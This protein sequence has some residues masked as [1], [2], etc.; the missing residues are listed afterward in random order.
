MSRL[1]L[2]VDEVG[3]GALA[4]PLTVAAVALYP[5]TDIPGVRDSK[6]LAP[7]YR[8]EL[9][10]RI[11]ELAAGWAI[12]SSAAQQIDTHG[13][14]AC[15]AAACRA[16]VN[17]CLSHLDPEVVI[18]VDGNRRIPGLKAPHQAVVKADSSVLAVSAA[19][20]IAKVWRDRYMYALAAVYP[21]FDFHKNVGYPTR[22]H[23]AQLK[24]HGPCPE[25]RRSYAPV[26]EVCGADRRVR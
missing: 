1:I 7:R 13:V 5:A 16:C 20:I 15:W 6:R 25:H 2:G 8:A 22:D 21:A 23:K 3:L 24:K 19:S 12:C 9:A 14:Y 11:M 17:T 10:P 18:I 26:K 4:G